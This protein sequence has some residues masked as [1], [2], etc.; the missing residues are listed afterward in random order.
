LFLPSSSSSLDCRDKFDLVAVCERRGVPLAARHDGRVAGH[1]HTQPLAV[2]GLT[3]GG[4]LAPRD[5]AD[6]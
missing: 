3:A 6:E 4:Q 5:L 2:G 1:R